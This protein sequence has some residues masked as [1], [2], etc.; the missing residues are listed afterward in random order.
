MEYDLSKPSPLVEEMDAQGWQKVFSE[1]IE[2][3]GHLSTGGD[4]VEEIRKERDR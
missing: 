3:I 4:S 1:L 2:E